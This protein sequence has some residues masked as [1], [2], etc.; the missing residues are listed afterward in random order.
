M[1]QERPFPRAAPRWLF[2]RGTPSPFLRLCHR[3]W[4][5]ALPGEQSV[6]LGDAWPKLT[7]LR[8]VS[9]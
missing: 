8:M 7:S 1:L 3:V 4:R 6:C 5:F 2:L 9:K